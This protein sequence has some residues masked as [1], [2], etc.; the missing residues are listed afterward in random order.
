MSY[1]GVTNGTEAQTT[2]TLNASVDP[3][4]GGAVTACHFEYVDSAEYSPAAHNP[5]SA[6]QSVSCSP[7]PLLLQPN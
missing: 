5:F 7:T 3:N 1:T 4:G 2:A 6:G